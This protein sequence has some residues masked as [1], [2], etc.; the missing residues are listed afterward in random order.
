MTKEQRITGSMTLLEAVS[1]YRETEEVFRAWG[2]TVGVCLL[3]KE[4]FE[5]IAYCAEKHGIDM[6]RL[7]HD[8]ECAAERSA[9]QLDQGKCDV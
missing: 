4:L 5:T 2:E 6:H 9:T 3:C 8:L 1:A 7:L